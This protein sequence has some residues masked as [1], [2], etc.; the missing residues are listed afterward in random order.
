[1]SELSSMK[2]LKVIY[3]KNSKNTGN[4]A[5]LPASCYYISSGLNSSFTWGTRLSTSSIIAISGNPIIDNVDKMLQDQAQCV[6]TAPS[7]NVQYKTIAVKG[8]RT[9]ASDAALSTLQGKG[10]TVIVTPV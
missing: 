8:T 9:S 3:L 7:G 1:M 10:Y 2:N 4:L 6:S 5:A